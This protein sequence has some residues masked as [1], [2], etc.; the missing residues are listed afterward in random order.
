MLSAAIY[1]RPGHLRACRRDRDRGKTDHLFAR[2]LE[3]L[4]QHA[5]TGEPDGAGEF[6]AASS[7]ETRNA[8]G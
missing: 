2:I 8:C 5:T 4:L 6:H 3:R 1:A 7:K